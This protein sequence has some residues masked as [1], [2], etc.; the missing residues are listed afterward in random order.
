VSQGQ[1]LHVQMRAT[2]ILLYTIAATHKTTL[3]SQDLHMD[4]VA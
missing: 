3:R 1:Y 4:K 2:N